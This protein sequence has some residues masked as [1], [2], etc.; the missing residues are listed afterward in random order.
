MKENQH[1]TKSKENLVWNKLQPQ[2]LKMCNDG[3]EHIKN[4]AHIDTGDILSA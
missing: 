2:L 4:V 1:E 3:L